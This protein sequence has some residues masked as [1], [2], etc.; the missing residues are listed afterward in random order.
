MSDVAHGQVKMVILSMKSRI[1]Q[2][3]VDILNGVPQLQYVAFDRVKVLISDFK[4][5][6]LPAAQVI[7]VSAE[8]KHEN[9]RSKYFWQ[10]TIELLMKAN[11]WNEV[12]QQDLWN[13]EYEV[14]RALFRVPNLGIPGVIQLNLLGTST[15]L[16]LL[17]PYY[18]ARMDLQVDFYEEAVRAC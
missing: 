10:I 7:D 4:D 8:H 3:I 16:H 15:D 5:V 1:A 18:F 12:N 6:D 11:E 9:V 17:M 14:K 2:K 13:L